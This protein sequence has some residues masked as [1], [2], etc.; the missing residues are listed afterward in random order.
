[1]DKISEEYIP[2][3][4]GQ[5]NRNNTKKKTTEKQNENKEENIPENLFD[6]LPFRETKISEDEFKP[7]IVTTYLP[8]G[9]HYQMKRACEKAGVNLVTKPG[10]KLKDILCGPNKTRHDKLDKPGIY[11]ITCPC[12]PKSKYVGQTT[13]PIST[14]IKEHKQA[15]EKGNWTHSGITQHRETCNQP[16]DWEPKVITNMLDKNKRRLIYDLKIRESLEIKRRNTG[17]NNGLNEDWGAYVKT[18]MWN[19]VFNTMS[20]R[21]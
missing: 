21:G 4:L 5:K 16:M 18:Q 12:D 3:S 2:P 8:G 9:I 13:R 15:A 1:M 17:P 7:F 10:V 19:P 6:V 11:E 14:R 20:D